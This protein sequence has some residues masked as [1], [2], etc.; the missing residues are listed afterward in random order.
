MLAL[1]EK[2]PNEE[3]PTGERAGY[4]WLAGGHKS[5][6]SRKCMQAVH[7]CGLIASRQ[8]KNSETSQA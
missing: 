8:S 2:N 6:E 7:A 4:L 1:E 5:P 3:P